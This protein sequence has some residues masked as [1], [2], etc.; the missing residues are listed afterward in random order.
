MRIAPFMP[1]LIGEQQI[2]NFVQSSWPL[3][4]S[5]LMA[6]FLPAA[7]GAIWLSRKEAV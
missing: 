2:A 1:V 7:L 5:F 6:L 4:G 3:A